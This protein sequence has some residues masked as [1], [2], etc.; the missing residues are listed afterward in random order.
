M[1]TILLSKRDFVGSYTLVFSSVSRTIFLE[2]RSVRR[3][4]RIGSRNL[5]YI[6]II[7]SG[8]YRYRYNSYGIIT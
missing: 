1:T 5:Y 4:V 6:V 3:L 7:S 8:F 2:P